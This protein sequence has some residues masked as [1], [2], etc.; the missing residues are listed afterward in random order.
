MKKQLVC[1][2]CPLGC[3]MEVEIENG[4]CRKVEGHSCP[5]GES[6]ARQECLNPTRMVTASILLPGRILPLSVR[7]DQAFPKNRIMECLQ[8]INTITPRLPVKV[9]DVL[10]PNVLDSGVNIIATRNYP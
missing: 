4:E 9:G 5:R 2:G 1:I 7:T 6:Y 8:A 3:R 10:L